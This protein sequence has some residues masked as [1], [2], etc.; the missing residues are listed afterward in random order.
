[1][2][3][4]DAVSLITPAIS[5]TLDKDTAQDIAIKT[6]SQR[7]VNELSDLSIL[8]LTP[9]Q[10]VFVSNHLALGFEVLLSRRERQRLTPKCCLFRCTAASL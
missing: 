3:N 1:M 2:I 7:L 9:Y 4:I 6:F 5:M 10:I 8:S